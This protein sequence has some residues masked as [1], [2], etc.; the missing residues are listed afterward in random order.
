MLKLLGPPLIGLTLSGCV[1]SP[2]EDVGLM[3]SKA[4]PP[5]ASLRSQIVR[6]AS[7]ILLSRGSFENAEISYVAVMADGSQWVCLRAEAKGE[8]S[9]DGAREAIAVISPDSILIGAQTNCPAC[10]ETGLQWLPFPEL[11]G[12]AN[13]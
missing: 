3:V 2:R 9:G 7:T 5:T 4:T 12:A 10:R 8:Q 11:E 1:Q 13:L 6:E